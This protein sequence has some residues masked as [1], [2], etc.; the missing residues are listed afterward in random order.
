MGLIQCTPNGINILTLLH[1]IVSGWILIVLAVIEVTLVA[2]IYGVEDFLNNI[3]AMGMKLPSALTWYWKICWQYFT[4]GALSI[5]LVSLDL[6][7]TGLLATTGL[8]LFIAEMARHSYSSIWLLK[9]SINY[10]K[11]SD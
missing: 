6:T 10:C 9:E 3:K 7:C 5:L 11:V 4:P 8:L 2:W 1:D